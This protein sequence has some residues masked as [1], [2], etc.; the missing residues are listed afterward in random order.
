MGFLLHCAKPLPVPMTL[1][2]PTLY[3]L[4]WDLNENGKLS[5]TKMHFKMSPTICPVG[6]NSRNSATLKYIAVFYKVLVYTSQN[7]AR[8]PVHNI[9]EQMFLFDIQSL[10]ATDDHKIW[11]G[12]LKTYHI[13]VFS[14]GHKNSIWEFISCGSSSWPFFMHFQWIHYIVCT[15]NTSEMASWRINNCRHI[16]MLTIPACLIGLFL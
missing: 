16:W 1:C 6:S 7:K 14:P 8:Y 13:Y 2:H 15:W 4:Y 11:L 9:V 12:I 10:R 3:K 5:F